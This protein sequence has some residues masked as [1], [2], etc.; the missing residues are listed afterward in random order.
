MTPLVLGP[1]LRGLVVLVQ[2]F[3]RVRRHEFTSGAQPWGR[4]RDHCETPTGWP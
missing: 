3:P 1:P 4:N 2:T